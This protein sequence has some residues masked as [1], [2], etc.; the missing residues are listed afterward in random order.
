MPHRRT[1]I[2]RR[3]RSADFGWS[4]YGTPKVEE[5]RRCTL[6][7]TF[8]QPEK[9]KICENAS[10]EGVVAAAAGGGYG[11]VKSNATCPASHSV[12]AAPPPIPQVE[13]HRNNI[14]GDEE[15][16]LQVLAELKKQQREVPFKA[17]KMGHSPL[18]A[19]VPI[20]TKTFERLDCTGHASTRPSP[21]S[22]PLVPSSTSAIPARPG[23]SP[24]S[25]RKRRR[26]GR[27]G[28]RAREEEGGGES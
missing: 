22:P 3:K 12:N 23:A 28:R 16:T 19:H 10:R 5:T 4:C 7:P 6:A 15:S 11:K 26:G 2:R 13:Q 8:H 17:T 25:R 18:D 27:R 20:C 14:V 24:P 21:V 1:S 9:M